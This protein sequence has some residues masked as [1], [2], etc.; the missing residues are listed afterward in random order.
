LYY[1]LLEQRVA[2]RTSALQSA[3]VQ[4]VQQKKFATIGQLIAGVA[5]EINN[6]V[7]CI[8]NNVTP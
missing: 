3:Q 6:P 1:T 2:E 4:L 7:G 8:V 5:H